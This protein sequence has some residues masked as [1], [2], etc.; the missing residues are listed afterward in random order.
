MFDID[1]ARGGDNFEFESQD[2]SFGVTLFETNGL[3]IGPVIDFVGKRTPEKLGA[4]LPKVGMAVELGGFVQQQFGE[5]F[6]IH[7]EV[8]QAVSGHD[9]LVAQLGADVI[10]RDGDEWLFSV[11]PRVK[12]AGGKYHDAYYSVTPAD[13]LATGLPVYDA[14]GGIHSAGVLAGAEMQF[15]PQWGIATYAGYERVVGSA[16]D[17][18]VVRQFGSRNQIS[19]GAALTFTFGRGVN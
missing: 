16:G 1:R 4:A 2:D 17:S 18:P 14:N 10:L 15:T 19:A 7:G 9:G 11:G 8:R 6:R 12:W 13:A 5:N 3:S